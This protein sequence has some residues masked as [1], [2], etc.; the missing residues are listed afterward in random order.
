MK[1]D[2]VLALEGASRSHIAAFSVLA[3]RAAKQALVLLLVSIPTARMTNG[4]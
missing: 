1:V 3:F 2:I 4:W